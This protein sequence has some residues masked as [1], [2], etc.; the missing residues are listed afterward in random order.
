MF[1]L[2]LIEIE[3]IEERNNSDRSKVNS[4]LIHL[5]QFISTIAIVELAKLSVVAIFIFIFVLIVD[6]PN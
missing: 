5:P 4:L 2:W 3:D 1:M 6:H